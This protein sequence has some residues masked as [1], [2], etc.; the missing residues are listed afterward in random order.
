MCMSRSYNFSAGPAVWPL[1]A[2]Q[3]TQRE[4]L[5]WHNGV[6][7]LEYTHRSHVFMELVQTLRQQFREILAVP[8]NYH[9][10][11]MQG[12]GTGQFSAIPLNLLRKKQTA[13]YVTTGFWSERAVH[14]AKLYCEVNIAASNSETHHR[15]I[16]TLNTWKLNS[17]AAFVHYCAN[18]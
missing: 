7:I 8:E 11:F 3:Q 2:L 5:D 15:N 13:D 18:E 6:S 1:E 9:I 4:L 16:P 17:E 12:G 14:E 10:I